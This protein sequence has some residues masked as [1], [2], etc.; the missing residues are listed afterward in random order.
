MSLFGVFNWLPLQ[1][2]G[3]IVTSVQHFPVELTSSMIDVVSGVLRTTQEFHM[4]NV[5]FV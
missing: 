4:T 5:T 3:Q 1:L 2:V